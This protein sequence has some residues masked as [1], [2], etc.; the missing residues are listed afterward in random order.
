MLS[1]IIFGTLDAQPVADT[2]LLKSKVFVLGEIVV[3]DKADK[4]SVTADKMQK[5]NR[6]DVASSLNLLPS[7]IIAN[8]GARN[9]GTIYMRGFDIRSVPVYADGIPVYVPYDGYVD[10]SRFTT[11]D[12][13][14]I[15]VSIGYSSVLFGANAMGGTINLISMKPVNKIE[16]R[17]K[18]GVMSGR[19]YLSYVN[20]GSNLGKLYFQGSFS[21]LN[22]EFLPLS[23]DFNT[24][25]NQPDY[26]L[27]NSHRDDTKINAKIGF[28]PNKTDEY[29]VNYIYQHG[30]KG[31]P[32]YLGSDSNI[33]LRYW[34]WPYWDKQS[35]YYIS[36][37]T[38]GKESHFKTRIY[39]DQFK[40]QVKSYDDN[41]YTSQTKKSSFTS[42]YNDKTYGA[43][44][45]AGTDRISKNN[46]RIA[47]HIKSD[48]HRE[49]NLDEPVR[50]ISDNTFSFGAEDIYFPVQGLKIVPGLSY[51]LRKSIKAEDYN[52]VSQ[53]I[54]DFPA[55]K[56]LA[57]DAQIAIYYRISKTIN[58]SAISARKTR[59]ATMKDRYSYKL[60]TAIPNPDLKAENA[61]NFELALN[62]D[63][64]DKLSIQPAVFYNKLNNAIQSVDEVQPGLSQMQNTGEAEFYGADADVRF[65][66]SQKI[67][68]TSNYSYI[69]RHNLTNPDIL[70]TDVPVH[71]IFA[72]L[73]MVPVHNLELNL[74]FEYNSERYSTSYGTVNPE[75]TLFNAQLSYVL[76]KYFKI[77]C[78]M[79]NIF[80]K[81]YSLIEGYPEAGR[82]IHA[83]LYFDLD[84]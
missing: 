29:S 56:N 9:E 60:G 84:H 80:D 23:H 34:Q 25:A 7:L 69:K 30:E 78:G 12:L 74:S 57:T 21:K 13:S 43:S 46:L 32:F 10:L 15:E 50:H 5:L 31:N 14:R 37:T 77:E 83:T 70:F 68:L 17:A 65:K 28:S 72:M 79:D 41:T 11:A 49:N 26:K 47:G 19:G 82:S 75:F 3:T 20:L 81:N 44:I 27:D 35:V 66:I 6:H 45:E 42:I 33:K 76:V 58:L 24:S 67:L 53:A 59:F 62:L 38:L 51:N 64:F 18:A 61:M 39:F 16:I 48:H 22:R 2:I 73:E 63:F 52:T 1:L 40:N 8:V 71:K 4:E 54:T 55:N 36:K